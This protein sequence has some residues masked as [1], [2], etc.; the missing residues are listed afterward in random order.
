MARKIPE[1]I[2]AFSHITTL[3]PGDVIP[4]GVNHQQ[5]GA[6]QD[7]D[8]LRMQIAELGPPLIV[9]IHDAQKRTWPRGIDQAFANMALGR[10]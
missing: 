4:T 7:G 3:E 2:E 10:R 8:V 9:T 1:L 6:V 5:I